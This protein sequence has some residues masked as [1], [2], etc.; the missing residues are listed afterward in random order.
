MKIVISG[1]TGFIGGEVLRQTLKNP[2]ITS[3]VVLSRKPLSIAAS[4]DVKVQVVLV[5]DFLHFSDAVMKA[6]EG[7]QGCVW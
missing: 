5:D 7:A 3:V 4:S 2:A 1:C 6:V